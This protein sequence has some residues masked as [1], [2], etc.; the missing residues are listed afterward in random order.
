MDVCCGRATRDATVALGQHSRK[1][2]DCERGIVVEVIRLD[3][4]LQQIPTHLL[5]RRIG[6]CVY[7]RTKCM[8]P[9]RVAR[10][11]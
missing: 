8:R 2:G 9:S 5:E 3:E 7:E 4:A 6:A 1:V 10:K 11:G